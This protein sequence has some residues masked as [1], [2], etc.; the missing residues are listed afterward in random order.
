MVDPPDTRISK[1]KDD[2][3]AYRKQ[4]YR[5]PDVATHYDA[6][7]FVG[8]SKKRRNRRKWAAIQRALAETDGVRS[9]LDIPCG[10]GRF[11]G[12][13]VGEEYSVVGGDISFEMMRVAQDNLGV[14]PGLR[15]YVQAEAENLPFRNRAFDCVMSIRF[16]FHVDPTV[17]VRMLREMV[18]IS[19]WLVVD[20]RHRYSYHYARWKV[21]R[22]LGLTTRKFVRVSRRQLE[23]ELRQAGAVL[24]RVHPVGRVFSDKWIVI[25]EAPHSD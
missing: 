15:G 13:L 7:R 14:L 21:E 18:R 2:S 16:L 19:R 25:A 1:P 11:T 5:D 3:Y 8:R 20:Y 23:D 6:E 24:K 17:R 10:T 4:F 12:H 22:A 9:I